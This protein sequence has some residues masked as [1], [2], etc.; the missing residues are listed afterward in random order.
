MNNGRP[1][2]SEWFLGNHASNPVVFTKTV[3]SDFVL[4]R[5]EV[6][7]V[8]GTAQG[9]NFDVYSQPPADLVG[10]THDGATALILA[11]ATLLTLLTNVV[12][13][14]SVARG[15]YDCNIPIVARDLTGGISG[16]PKI[17]I[18]LT[19][20]TPGSGKLFAVRFCGIVGSQ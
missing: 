16:P 20:T 6:V 4:T 15:A 8:R 19:I 9:F 5:V 3:P 7:Q 2:A 12:V 18:K 14:T 13:A 10:Y 17:E 1:Y 11:E